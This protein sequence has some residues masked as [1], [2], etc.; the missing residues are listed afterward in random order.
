MMVLPL[1]KFENTSH[2]A[3]RRSSGIEIPIFHHPFR[4]YCRSANTED[5]VQTQLPMIAEFVEHWRGVR[6][7]REEIAM[8]D[9]QYKE[10]QRLAFFRRVRSALPQTTPV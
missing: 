3:C 7:A 5:Y 1:S 10:E 8:L 4:I 6:V 2:T 9:V